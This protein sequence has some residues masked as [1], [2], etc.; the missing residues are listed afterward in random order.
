MKFQLVADCCTF[1][2]SN[3]YECAINTSIDNNCIII[4]L[5]IKIKTQPEEGWVSRGS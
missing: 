3:K 2:Q 5:S 1:V 4:P